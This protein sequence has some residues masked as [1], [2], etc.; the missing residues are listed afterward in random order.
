LG[1]H[2]ANWHHTEYSLETLAGL[3]ELEASEVAQLFERAYATVLPYWDKI[4]ALLEQDAER[5]RKWYSRSKLEKD[6]MPI[7]QRLWA[8]H[9]SLRKGLFSYWLAYARKYPERLVNVAH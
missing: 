2:F 4:A 8:I 9:R 1:W 7:N 6:L 5:F 3:R